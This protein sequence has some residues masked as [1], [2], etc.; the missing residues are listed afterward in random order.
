MN[1]FRNLLLPAFAVFGL[2]TRHNILSTTHNSSIVPTPSIQNQKMI[3]ASQTVSQFGET[4]SFSVSFPENGGPINGAITGNCTG[5]IHGNYSG[6]TNGKKLSGYAY[7]TCP[8]LF[9]TLSG[10]AKFNGTVN[11]NDTNAALNYTARVNG[12]SQNGSVNLPLSAQ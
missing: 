12:S 3:T 2:F 9:F 4:A 5:K 6:D 8:V 10:N 1:G 7:A 11:N